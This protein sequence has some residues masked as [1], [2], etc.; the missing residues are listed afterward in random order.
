MAFA[1]AH[2]SAIAQSW[3]ARPVTII[4]P[5]T[6]GTTSDIVA[7]GLAQYMTDTLGQPF[8]VDNRGGAGARPALSSVTFNIAEVQPSLLT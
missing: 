6:A 2:Q 1:L 4:V 5:F 3:P 7:R 8:A